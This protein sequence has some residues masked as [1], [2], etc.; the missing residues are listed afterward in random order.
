MLRLLLVGVALTGL[1]CARDEGPT[2]PADAVAIA[3]TATS[4]RGDEDGGNGSLQSDDVQATVI[5]T[6]VHARYRACDGEDGFY[7][8]SRQTVYYGTSTGDPRLSGDFQL[9]ATLDLFN[10]TKLNGPQYGNVVIRDPVTGRK[11]AEGASSA[12]G[13]AGSNFVKGTIVGFVRDERGGAGPTSGSGHWVAGFEFKVRPDGAFVLQIGGMSVDNR[14]PGGIW[15]GGCPGG[16]FTVE[17]VDFP[18]VGTAALAART[19]NMKWLRGFK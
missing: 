19:S 10:V 9:T 3:N 7:F 14:M 15:S 12:W 17:E 1:A 16:K 11:K 13:D 4:S 8:E 18:P 6:H 2:T 5:M